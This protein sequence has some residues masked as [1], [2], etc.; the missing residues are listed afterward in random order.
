MHT[1]SQSFWIMIG[2]CL[3][4]AFISAVDDLKNG[5]PAIV[6]LLIQS[7]VVTIGLFTLPQTGQTFWGYLPI[8]LDLALTA[9]M[10]LWFLNL[11]NFMDGIDGLAGSQSIT[12]GLGI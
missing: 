5:I 8:E 2:L 3:F 6:R 4:L 11:F 7:I 12:I 9:I 1:T 10:W